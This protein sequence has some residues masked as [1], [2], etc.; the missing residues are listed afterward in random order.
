MLH[1][2]AL[3][4]LV[5]LGAGHSS[6]TKPLPRN[7]RD[8]NLTIFRAGAFV[9]HKVNTGRRAFCHSAAP[10][11]LRSAGASNRDGGR[12]RQQADRT[13]AADGAKVGSHSGCSCTGPEG[14]CPSH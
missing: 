2:L 9:Q 4:G 1:A 13:L 10:P 3:A 8:R 7:A 11:P 14:G 5:G 12:E 6:M